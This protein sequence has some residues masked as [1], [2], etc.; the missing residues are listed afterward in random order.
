M[1]PGELQKREAIIAHCVKMNTSGLNQGTSGNIS[2]RHAD[3]LLISPTSRPYENLKPDDIVYLEMDGTPH[4]KW[5]PSSEWRF[6]RDILRER[7]DANAVIH[8]HPT[9]CTILSIMGLEIPAIHYLMASFGGSNI[10]CAPYA[11]YGSAELSE[12][13]LVALQDRQACLLAHHGMITT[14]S[15]IEKTYWLAEQL[16]TLARQYHGCL[17]LGQPPLLSDRQ[18]QDVIDKIDGYGLSDEN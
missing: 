8:A 3:G 13:A 11:I 17:Q 4:G 15:S 9:H 16:E 7:L 12:L 14:G 6:H 5:K 1:E 2:I 18:I 10:R